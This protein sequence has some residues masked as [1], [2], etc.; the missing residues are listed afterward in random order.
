M[1]KK[2]S[3]KVHA[4]FEK[5]LNMVKEMDELERSRY[6]MFCVFGMEPF[7]IGSYHS[8]FGSAIGIPAN[9]DY[10]KPSDIPRS[11]I[12]LNNQTVP[13]GSEVGKLLEKSLIFTEDEQIF[14]ML[15]EILACRTWQWPLNC[16]YSTVFVISTY[17]MALTL[18]NKLNLRQRP[19]SLRFVMYALV[20]LFNLGNFCFATDST[21]MYYDTAI[22]KEIASM[23]EEMVDAGVR[24]YE[25]VLNRNIAIRTFTGDFSVYSSAGNV[26]M[27][28]RQKSMP[29]TARKDFFQE[30]LKRLKESSVEMS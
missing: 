24:Y 30:Q 25:K 10:E 12:V 29:F 27:F 2:L 5:A 17:A 11:E 21:Q 6:K 26:N 19:F 15:K 3:D 1:E 8:V 13:W 14:A 4:R 18:N 20:G 22:D 23:G 7:H 9:F 16:F 28:V